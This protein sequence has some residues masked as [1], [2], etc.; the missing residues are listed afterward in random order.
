MFAN[1]EEAIADLLLEF[2]CPIYL[3]PPRYLIQGIN[4]GDQ[5]DI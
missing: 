3:S 1:D 4:N 2:G 5:L